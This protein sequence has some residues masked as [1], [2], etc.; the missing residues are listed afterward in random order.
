M[1]LQRNIKMEYNVLPML[2]DFCP[3]SDF[4][5]PDKAVPFL[6]R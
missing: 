5:C 2:R 4:I 1:V 6:L 3:K